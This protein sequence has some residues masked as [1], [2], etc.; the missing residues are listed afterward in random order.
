MTVFAAI[1]GFVTG[2]PYWVILLLVVFNNAISAMPAPD[3]TTGKGYKWMF[4][5]LHGL[6]IPRLLAIFWPATAEQ[7]R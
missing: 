7:Q 4:S 6:N 5:F 1:N 3:A 2:H